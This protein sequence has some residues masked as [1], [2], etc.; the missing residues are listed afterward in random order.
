MCL[1][2]QEKSDRVCCGPQKVPASLLEE[3]E[4][5]GT[6]EECRLLCPLLMGCLSKTCFFPGGCETV[7][8]KAT[9]SNP[10]RLSNSKL[11]PNTSGKSRHVFHFF[12][13]WGTAKLDLREAN[14]IFFSQCFKFLRSSY[15][16]DLTLIC[17]VRRKERR[18]SKCKSNILVQPD[19]TKVT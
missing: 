3:N 15:E 17:G 11:S 1:S 18:G 4:V 8:K 9:F 16:S 13:S 7:D 14:L 12:V 19:E 6:E 5:W 10:T 2:P